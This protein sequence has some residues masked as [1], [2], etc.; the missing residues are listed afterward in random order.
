MTRILIIDDDAAV[1]GM[2][3]KLIKSR[4]Y[5]PIVAENALVG[6]AALEAPGVDAVFCDVVLPE[7]DGL[8]FLEQ[9]RRIDQDVPVILMSAFID[10]RKITRAL[11]LNAFD[12]VEKPFDIATIDVT[13]AKTISQ[14]R[15]LLQQRRAQSLSQRVEALIRTL[16]ASPDLDRL[17]GTLTVET[18]AALDVSDFGV[19]ARVGE[20]L[21]VRV[22]RGRIHWPEGEWPRPIREC[23]ELGRVTE[24]S[25]AVSC[26][27]EGEEVGVGLC[28]PLQMEMQRWGVLSM[29]REEGTI[30]EI[31]R[32]LFRLVA[33]HL[34]SSITVRE[35]SAELERALRAL[36]E[37]QG[38][39]LRTEKLA[40][41]TKLVAG[42]AHEIK[43]PLTSMQFAV[44]NARSE[45]D[46]LEPDPNR[47]AGLSRFLDLF[48]SDVDRLRER[49]DR[50]MDLARPDAAPRDQV[51][52]GDHLRHVVDSAA[53]RATANSIDLSLSLPESLPALELDPVGFENAVL[54]LVVNAIEAIQ[55]DGWVKV[56]ASYDTDT[57]VVSV[58][59]SGP[60]LSVEARERMFDIFYT[61]KAKG[62]GLGLSQV[63]VFVE[64]HGG[65][66][67]WHSTPAATRFELRLPR[68]VATRLS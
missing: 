10:H 41:V 23:V 35:R 58:E 39:L 21:E 63:H 22:G 15:L 3:E 62:A 25:T 18:S 38:R 53:A 27:G 33:D 46:D 8:E 49:V 66:V 40:S 1:R 48:A 47:A 32:R 28:L 67:H 45:L 14:R 54:N 61:T 42:L 5:E 13:L 29:F 36:E 17:Y 51:N 11:Q 65:D 6:L 4:G 12:L 34:A 52:I 2:L 24:V 57:V 60:G 9:A 30:D 19:F 64:I 7:M 20:S 50:F 31:D 16:N 59:D 26:F 55:S 37:A 43:N 68:R 56:G 44:A